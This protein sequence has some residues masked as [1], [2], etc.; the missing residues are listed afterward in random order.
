MHLVD[1][2]HH[3]LLL[4]HGPVNDV[5][6][7]AMFHFARVV[8]TELGIEYVYTCLHQYSFSN[9]TPLKLCRVTFF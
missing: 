2:G 8:H 3:L 9:T 1:H 4:S 6:V 5:A 7:C